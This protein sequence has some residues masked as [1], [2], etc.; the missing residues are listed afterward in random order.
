MGRPSR[1]VCTVTAA[2]G[3]AV[4]CRVSGKVAPVANG[5]IAVPTAM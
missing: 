2:A 1:L 4:T 3:R 5:Q